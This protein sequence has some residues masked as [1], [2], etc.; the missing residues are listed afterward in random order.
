MHIGQW[1]PTQVGAGQLPV[2]RPCICPRGW[3]W[4]TAHSEVTPCSSEL[5]H[6]HGGLCFCLCT[7]TLPAACRRRPRAPGC[8]FRGASAPCGGCDTRPPQ[9]AGVCPLSQVW[10][11]DVHDGSL[12]TEA[13]GS[14]G[15]PPPGA[16]RGPVPASFHCWWPQASLACGCISPSPASVVTSRPLLCVCLWPPSTSLLGTVPAFRA[17]ADNPGSAP[18]PTSFTES[19]LRR[20]TSKAAPLPG[21]GRGPAGPRGPVSARQV[22]QFLRPGKTQHSSLHQATRTLTPCHVQLFSIPFSFLHNAA[23]TH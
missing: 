20:L 13:K 22:E 23:V 21:P 1:P 4:P 9:T 2:P 5:G 18:I 7:R 10:R 14:A 6:M 11:P 12:C 3:F 16:V 17:Q 19:Q 15:L 8:S